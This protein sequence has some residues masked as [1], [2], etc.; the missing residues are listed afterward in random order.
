MESHEPQKWKPGGQKSN[1]VVALRHT[2]RAPSRHFS[3][4]MEGT[5]TIRHATPADYLDYVRFASENP[6]AAI[7][8]KPNL[9]FQ[10]VF[11]QQLLELTR[12]GP[13][14]DL[15]GQS[16]HSRIVADLWN[17]LRG[18]LP[19]EFWDGLPMAVGELD[20]MEVNAFC[21]KS[22]EGYIAVVINSGLMTLLNKLSKITVAVT[23]PSAVKYC[24]RKLKK[25]RA[26]AMLQEIQREVCANY[27]QTREPL[28]PQM[29]LYGQ[30]H[31]VHA[32]QLHVWEMFVLCHEIAHV[33]CGHL[34]DKHQMVSE[35]L[36]ETTSLSNDSD[37]HRQ[38]TQ[39]DCTGLLLL[40]EYLAKTK[41]SVFPANDDRQL[42]G[43]LI[44]LFNHLFEIGASESASHP[45]PMI[46][47]R[48]MMEFVYGERFARL[49]ADSY[50]DLNLIALLF[51]SPVVP[52]R[53]FEECIAN[54]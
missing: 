7:Q 36:D 45:H 41:A 49:V 30:A 35:V 37:A 25:K 22:E 44:T 50:R 29:I 15:K 53:T 40:K 4:L 32:T 24:S 28:G 33:L 6:M 17:D 1:A 27:R 2:T 48:N 5:L 13:P 46:R 9:A 47:L 54:A 11:N 31:H 34:K 39:A 51:Q 52:Q 19:E 26:K 3:Q 12:N 38:E 14:L 43:F 18:A 16:P 23:Q 20:N 8:S 42:I 21:S 10:R